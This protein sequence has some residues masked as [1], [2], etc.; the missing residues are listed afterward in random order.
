MSKK[1]DKSAST[2][3]T[4]SVGFSMADVCIHNYKL[5]W[6][7]AVKEN[8]DQIERLKDEVSIQRRDRIN[9]ELHNTDERINLENELNLL[10]LAFFDLYQTTFGNELRWPGDSFTNYLD[11]HKYILDKTLTQLNKE[12][13]K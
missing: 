11:K 8:K 13:Y 1:R 5:G 10:R 2:N 6:D 4:S 9:I 3:F 12:I 7:D